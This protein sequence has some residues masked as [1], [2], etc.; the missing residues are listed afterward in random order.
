[1]RLSARRRSGTR[2]DPVAGERLLF[3]GHGERMRRT[4]RMLVVVAPLLALV[5]SGCASS[6]AR[7][8]A[9]QAA[10]VAIKCP[11]GWAAGWQRLARRVDAPV[12]CPSWMPQPL[13]GQIGSEYSPAPYVAKD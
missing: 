10:R 9:H 6:Y 11:T 7:P 5:A 1:M 4:Y 12:Y 2:P 8:Q 3:P 13:V